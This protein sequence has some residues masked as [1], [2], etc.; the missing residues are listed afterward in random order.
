MRKMKGKIPKQ[1]DIIWQQFVVSKISSYTIWVLSWGHWH[2]IGHQRNKEIIDSTNTFLVACGAFTC[3]IKIFFLCPWGFHVHSFLP[4]CFSCLWGFHLCYQN[5]FLVPMG[6]SCAFLSTSLF[7]GP[8]TFDLFSFL[9]HQPL[10][11]CTFALV[12]SRGGSE[13]TL[14]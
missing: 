2:L 9:D 10:L 3:V 5:I 1:K 8:S 6:L 7:H 13:F 14:A 4:V 12:G 11:T